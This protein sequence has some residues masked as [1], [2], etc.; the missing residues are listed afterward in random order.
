VGEVDQA[1]QHRKALEA[2]VVN[3]ADLE[4][5]GALL[6]RFNIF[7]AVG[8]VWQEIRH[9]TFLAFLLD[10][11]ASHGLGDAFAKRLLQEAIMSSPDATTP[12][13]PIELSLWD[14]G[15]M[16]VR[17]E[18]KRIDIF[19]LDEQEKLAVVI[20]N[21]IGAGE[22]GDQLDRYHTAVREEY[23]DHKL[24]A[25]YLT[26][27]GDEPSHPEYLPVDYRTVCEILDELAESRA[28][29]IEP[30]AKVLIEH[31][32]EM[33][34]RHIVGDSEIARLSRQ[35]YQKHKRAIDLIIE[36]R[37]ESQETVREQ[38]RQLC[39]FLIDEQ[40]N[41]V[42]AHNGKNKIGFDVQHWNVPETIFKFEFWNYPESL[43]LKLFIGPGSKKVRQGLFQMVRNNSE[44]FASQQG[45]GGKWSAAYNLQLLE[46]S[47]Y[48]EATDAEREVEIRKNWDDFLEN[49][50]PRIDEALK[51][52]AW[53]WESGETGE[54]S[55]D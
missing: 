39:N 36:H 8:F 6:D 49:D 32:T 37:Y 25:L 40:Q 14:L 42:L 51:K 3:N 41:F 43:E 7:E 50:L 12:V 13:T 9:S 28:S 47:F 45:L 21:K 16:E 18:W 15:Q 4:R 52:E 53:I 5:L 38:L 54:S 27:R 31:Y 20:E 17:R 55:E 33:L 19:L 23:P 11:Q 22:H 29:V 2:F 46:E 24:L 35:I 34:R 44:V 26:P 1:E 30:D 48:S 10:P